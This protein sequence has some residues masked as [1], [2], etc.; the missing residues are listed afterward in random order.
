MLIW[1]QVPF[2]NILL[3]LHQVALQHSAP[4]VNS[5]LVPNR[6]KVEKQHLVLNQQKVEKW[7]LV[8]IQLE[9]E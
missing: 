5:D 9:P 2:F 7:H 1:D 8:P 6:Q 4:N 3:N